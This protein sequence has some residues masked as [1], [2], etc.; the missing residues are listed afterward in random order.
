MG[1]PQSQTTRVCGCSASHRW[2]NLGPVSAVSVSVERGQARPSPHSP[3]EVSWS[4]PRSLAGLL[5]A[6]IMINA[7]MGM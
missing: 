2:W 6:V 5:L 4:R 7:L 3:A 1:C